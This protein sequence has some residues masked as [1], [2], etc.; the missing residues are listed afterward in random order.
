MRAGDDSARDELLRSVCDRLERLTRKM[1]RSFPDVERWE[2][3]QDVLNVSLLKL[4]KALDEVT[5]HSVKAFYSLAATQIRRQLLDLAKHYRGAYGLGTNQASN[6]NFGVSDQSDPRLNPPDPHSDPH[7][8]DLWIG[9]HE[10]VEGLPTEEREVLSLVFYHGWKRKDIAELFQVDER[11]VRRKWSS[12]CER[13]R[14]AL[15]GR[16]PNIAD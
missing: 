6:A 1:L 8:L 7:D 15:F 14:K 2:Q 13:L 12:A 4:L 10:A 9:F 3:T 5:P 16:V 11:T